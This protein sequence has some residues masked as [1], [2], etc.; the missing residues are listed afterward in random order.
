[1]RMPSE[2]E[3]PRRRWMPRRIRLPLGLGL[4]CVAG[5]LV[6]VFLVTDGDTAT[7][8]RLHLATAATVMLL[9]GGVALVWRSPRRSLEVGS[10]RALVA[11]LS[12]LGAAQLT[13]S[14]G[15][16]AWAPDG[17][18]LRSTALQSVHTAATAVGAA[19]VIAVVISTVA[20]SGAVV[21]RLARQAQR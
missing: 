15:A 2:K 11:A 14:V 16:L 8:A 4:S 7:H 10:R 18:T 1:M 19:A 17:E 20:A 21:V 3:E 12:L 5:M 13:E 6:A 9:A